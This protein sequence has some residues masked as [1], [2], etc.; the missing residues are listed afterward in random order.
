MFIPPPFLLLL[1]ITLSYVVSILFPML[2]YNGLNMSLLGLI[3]I[4]SGVTLFVWGAKTLHHHKTTL[5]PRKKP[6]KLIMHGPYLYTRNPIYLGFFLVTIGTS[7]LFANV[8]A[9]VG[10]LLFFAFISTF[11]IPFEEE[12][13]SKKFG[14]PYHSYRKKTRR[15][16]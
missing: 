5:H 13:L 4:T 15:W 7:L 6:S 9:F 2:Q 3:F 14:K 8:L 10:P 1:A 11:I 12:M 16:V